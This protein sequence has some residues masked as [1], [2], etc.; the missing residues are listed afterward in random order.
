MN[1]I[2]LKESESGAVMVEF[3]LVST[4]LILLLVGIIEFGMI[5]NTQLTLQNAAREGA[6]FA[7]IPSQLSEAQIEILINNSATTFQLNSS[8][9]SITPATR[10]RGQQVI[11]TLNYP[12]QVPVTFGILPETYNLTATAVMM[13]E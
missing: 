8:Q 3:A 5:F 1:M 2:K 12:Y 9:I 7:A 4:F 6:R 10:Q 11:V 13:Q